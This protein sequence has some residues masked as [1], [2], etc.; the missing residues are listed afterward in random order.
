MFTTHAH[1][2]GDFIFVS[3]LFM[4]KINVQKGEISLITLKA[5]SIYLFIYL[6]DSVGSSLLCRLFSSCGERGLLSS[7]GAQASRYRGFFGCRT[8]ALG[9]S[10]SVVLRLLGF[11][12][13]A[14]KL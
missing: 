1:I 5:E 3:T 8:Q 12:A 13:Q 11:R 2:P 10:G 4:F 9:Y 6:F 14:Q 7:W